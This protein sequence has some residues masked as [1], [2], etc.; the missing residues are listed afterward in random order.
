M[1]GTHDVLFTV[2]CCVL[3]FAVAGRTMDT[4]PFGY[5]TRVARSR[6]SQAALLQL[7]FLDLDPSFVDA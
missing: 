5:E 1:V 7:L 3:L 2:A 4:H 6:L